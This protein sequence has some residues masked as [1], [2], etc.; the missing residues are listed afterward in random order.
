MASV[1][2]HAAAIAAGGHAFGGARGATTPREPAAPLLV[3][4][5]VAPDPV[6]PTVEE[7]TPH[8]VERGPAV[9]SPHRHPYPVAPSHDARPHDASI[10][11]AP[12]PDVTAAAA[13]N[14]VEAS[15]EA[16]V[17]FTLPIGRAVVGAVTSAIGAQGNGDSGAESAVTYS[18]SQVN[19]PA[20]LLAG[21]PVE[22]P[23]DARA[24]QIEDDLTLEIVVDA[25]GRV[26][27]ARSTSEAGHGLDGA[28]VAAVRRYRF[29]PALRQ[30]RPVAVR[31][32]W[33]VQFRL[34]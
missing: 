26:V 9:A 5:D 21:A 18:E 27:Q 31:M 16:P 32:R 17:R 3:D 12:L 2:L 14:V 13:P 11:H 25:S 34:R 7:G 20:R 6:V 15:A 33:T 30:G 29:S 4:I 8:G 10:L 19:V 1:A 23:A 28:A 24:V 22:Y